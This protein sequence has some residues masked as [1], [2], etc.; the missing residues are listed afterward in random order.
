MNIDG[1]VRNLLAIFEEHERRLFQH[2]RETS[3]ITW[4]PFNG[5]IIGLLPTGLFVLSDFTGRDPKNGRWRA[6][7]TTAF[8]LDG[9]IAVDIRTSGYIQVVY[10]EKN[11]NYD[12]AIH[13]HLSGGMHDH[14][15]YFKLDFNVLGTANTV[16]L[17]RTASVTTSY[18]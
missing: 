8:S 12:F 17:V 2:T 11:E 13:D 1:K 9:S 18:P 5:I 15:L 4:D 3:D 10:R 16:A 14:V 6:G 7:C